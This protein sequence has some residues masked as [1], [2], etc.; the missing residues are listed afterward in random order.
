MAGGCT[1]MSLGNWTMDGNHCITAEE[2]ECIRRE[3]ATHLQEK[4]RATCNE[5]TWHLSFEYLPP[6]Y[7]SAG[8]VRW[9]E[10]QYMEWNQNKITASL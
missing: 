7:H 10:K 9:A 4:S 1:V 3:F 5:Q 6:F 2:G 8:Q